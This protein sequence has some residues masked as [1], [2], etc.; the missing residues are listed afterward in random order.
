MKPST[1]ILVD[2]TKIDRPPL[3]IMLF[4]SLQMISSLIFCCPYLPSRSSQGDI[5]HQWLLPNYKPSN[6]LQQQL[7]T[8]TADEK[9]CICRV[10]LCSPCAGENVLLQSDRP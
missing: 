9:R 1:I 4:L 2:H 5:L 6:Q 3:P 10:C 7:H 8:L